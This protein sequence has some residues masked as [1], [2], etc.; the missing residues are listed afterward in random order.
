[1]NWG[2]PSIEYANCKLYFSTTDEDYLRSV[3][4]GTHSFEAKLSFFPKCDLCH[5]RK[6]ERGKKCSSCKVGVDWH[7]Y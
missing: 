2:D 1:M 7:F 3:A 4:P 5:R 6:V